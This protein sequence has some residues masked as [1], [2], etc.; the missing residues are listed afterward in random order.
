MDYQGHFL[1]MCNTLN[2]KN[3]IRFR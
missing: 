1:E 2:G 3:A